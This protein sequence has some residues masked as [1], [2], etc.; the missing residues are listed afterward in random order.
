MSEE[1]KDLTVLFQKRLSPVIF[2][3]EEKQ[4]WLFEEG[5]D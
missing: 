1:G 4:T 3:R 2:S 5:Q